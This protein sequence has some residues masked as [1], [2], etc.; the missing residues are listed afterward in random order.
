[1]REISRE[2]HLMLQASVREALARRHA[3]VTVEHLLY[4][5]LHD[6]Q[7]G[8]IL[9]NSG[10]QLAVLKEGLGQSAAAHVL[11]V[12]GQRHHV[13]DADGGVAGRV[14]PSV[15]SEFMT[16]TA[17]TSLTADE[18]RVGGLVDDL[19]THFPP[20]ETTPFEFLGQL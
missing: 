13:Q 2:L 5:A 16:M 4:A 3:Y 9:R 6:E 14:G 17:E 1:M 10:A 19:L 12:A 7:G 8:D 11:Q 18:R 15:D 20:A